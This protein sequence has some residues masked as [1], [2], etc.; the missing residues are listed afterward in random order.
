MQRCWA[1][2]QASGETPRGQPGTPSIETRMV[3]AERGSLGEGLL[4]MT[5]GVAGAIKMEECK[6]MIGERQR[7][8][9]VIR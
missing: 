5:L 6:G 3:A 1:R 9:S 4:W 7:R 2:G 8:H